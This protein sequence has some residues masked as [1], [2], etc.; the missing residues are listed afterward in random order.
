MEI[1]MVGC[2]KCGALV[3]SV[4]VIGANRIGAA[5][6]AETDSN[7]CSIAEA[8][9]PPMD[10]PP[11]VRAFVS[12]GWHIQ[13]SAGFRVCCRGVLSGDRSLAAA[14]E[15]LRTSLSRKWLGDVPLP[16]W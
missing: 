16:A 1:H 3:L 6:L 15:A 7:C 12:G 8:C 11:D 13:E 2:L 9:C 14:I 4:V 10:T 5:E